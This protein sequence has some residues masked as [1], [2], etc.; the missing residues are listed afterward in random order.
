MVTL[1][2]QFLQ[3]SDGGKGLFDPYG[4][5]FKHVDCDSQL[6]PRDC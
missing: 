5:G 3:S 2:A 4:S 1:E 6:Q